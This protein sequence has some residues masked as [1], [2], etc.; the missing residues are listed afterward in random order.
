M[1]LFGHQLISCEPCRIGRRFLRSGPI[2]WWVH[3]MALYLFIHTRTAT[4]NLLTPALLFFLIPPRPYSDARGS[5]RYNFPPNL[6]ARLA[7][8][9]DS[10]P[11]VIS[12][13]PANKFNKSAHCYFLLCPIFVPCIK[14]LIIFDSVR[15][16]CC[17][18]IRLARD[19]THSERVRETMKESGR[20]LNGVHNPSS[21]TFKKKYKVGRQEVK[22]S[23]NRG[24][25]RKKK[26]S[27]NFRISIR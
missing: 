16:V 13:F 17:F 5:F 23:C 10:P 9:R 21:I 14:M 24:L 26:V 12:S 8:T 3:H 4:P 6:T 20:R 1:S 25:G 27:L 2:C 15:A 7:F 22:K 11:H 18:F 19:E